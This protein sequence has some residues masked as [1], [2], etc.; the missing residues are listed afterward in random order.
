MRWQSI[1]MLVY[2]TLYL[3]ILA[4]TY[5]VAADQAWLEQQ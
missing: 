1:R 5:A 2:R 3:L 4:Y